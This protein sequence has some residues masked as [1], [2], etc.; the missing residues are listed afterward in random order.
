V[1]SSSKPD[2]WSLIFKRLSRVFCSISPYWVIVSHAVLGA[3]VVPR[4]TMGDGQ[5]SAFLQSFL[6]AV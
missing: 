3:T 1:S 5:F 6:K 2:I 4:G